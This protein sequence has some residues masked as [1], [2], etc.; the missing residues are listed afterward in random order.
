MNTLK[1]S[2]HSF[3][4][5]K[6]LCRSVITHSQLNV[7]MLP[8]CLDTD[9]ISKDT[10]FDKMQSVITLNQI[11]SILVPYNSVSRVLTTPLYGIL[12]DLNLTI[13]YEE[14]TEDGNTYITTLDRHIPV[15]LNEI[16]IAGRIYQVRHGFNNRWV[17]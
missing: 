10:L 11:D 5:L 13:L 14:K 12:K 16:T 2:E 6:Q 15:V 1:L 4:S 3:S 8:Q 17:K 7:K 9:M